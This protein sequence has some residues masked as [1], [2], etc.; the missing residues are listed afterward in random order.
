[1]NPVVLL[2]IGGGVAAYKVIEVA[3]RL[4]Q[5]HF[6][7]YTAMTPG[8]RHFINPLTFEAVTNNPVITEMFPG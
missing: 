5:E 2:G 1:M 8:A 4:K 6:N 3:S 7:V